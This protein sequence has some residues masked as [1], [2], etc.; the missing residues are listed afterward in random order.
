ML[1]FKELK[2]INKKKLMFISLHD[3]LFCIYLVSLFKW[4]FHRI[5]HTKTAYLSRVIYQYLGR[6]ILKFYKRYLLFFTC[7]KN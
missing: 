4:A 2:N 7:I 6:I 3:K 1:N 5:I